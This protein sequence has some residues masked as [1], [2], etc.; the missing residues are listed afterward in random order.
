MEGARLATAGDLPRV[1][2]LARELRTELA[3]YRGGALWALRDGSAEPL[4]SAFAALLADPHARLVVGTID[5]VVVGYAVLVV[6]ELRDGSHLG[7]IG[8]LFVE[9]PARGVG[10]GE[11]IVVLLADECHA[12][13]CRGIDVVA[14]PG[15]RATK[16]FLEAQGF[17]ARALVMHRQLEGEA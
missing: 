10:T 5:E 7:Q 17:T 11:A 4:D 14:L 15:H 1:V 6:D 9:P 12:M 8:E 3:A 2:E 13:G 16:N